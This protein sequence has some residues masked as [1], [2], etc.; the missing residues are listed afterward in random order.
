MVSAPPPADG[1]NAIDGGEDGSPDELRS[2]ES[3][4]EAPVSSSAQ[5]AGTTT[6]DSV[7]GDSPTDGQPSMNASTRS[8]SRAPAHLSF[9][10]ARFTLQSDDED[11]L[12]YVSDDE[13]AKASVATLESMGLAGSWQQAGQIK[14]AIQNS[15]PTGAA[16]SLRFQLPVGQSLQRSSTSL[17]TW[18]IELAA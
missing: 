12:T 4:P 17:A 5:V 13:T 3:P 10:G 6:G 1:T 15:G 11:T 18:G 8:P 2:L 14:I 7:G 16:V 9:A